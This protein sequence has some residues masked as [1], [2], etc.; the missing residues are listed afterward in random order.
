MS[1]APTTEL[2]AAQRHAILAS[3]DNALLLRH[4]ESYEKHPAQQPERSREMARY[5]DDLTDI[6][7]RSTATHVEAYVSQIMDDICPQ[8]PH[9][10]PSGYCRLRNKGGC[11]LCRFTMT[12]IE[13]I[14]DALIKMNDYQYVINHSPKRAARRISTRRHCRREVG[15]AAARAR[16]ARWWSSGRG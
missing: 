2:T 16:L 10:E 14:A 4:P 15:T 11:V 1:A 3:I 6:V 9:Q 8:C 7:R 13:A 12:I 5:I